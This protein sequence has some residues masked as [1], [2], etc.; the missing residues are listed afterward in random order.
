MAANARKP[1]PEAIAATAGHPAATPRAVHALGAADLLEL[2]ERAEG[3]DRAEQALLVLAS[4]TG[5]DPRDFAEVSIPRRDALLFATRRLA[6]GDELRAIVGCPDCGER[7]EFT[8][9][10]SALAPPEP[11]PDAAVQF[12]VG[13]AQVRIRPPTTADLLAVR[14]SPNVPAARDALLTRCIVSL[15]RDGT[16]TSA[17]SLDGAELAA[18]AGQASNHPAFADIQLELN[19][20][21]CG[22]IWQSAFDVASFLWDELAAFAARLLPEVHTIARAYGWSEREILALSPGRRA[23]YLDLIEAGA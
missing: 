13:D 5:G 8:T 10:A 1:E 22:A 17:A 9:L 20:A 7:L 4:A 19:C 2:W 11:L 6:F 14:D 15:T 12:A 23:R 3:R 21:A 18:L 16:P